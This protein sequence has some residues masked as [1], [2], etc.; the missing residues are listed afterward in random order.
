MTV[1]DLTR[2]LANQHLAYE[3]LP[4]RTTMTAGEEAVAIGI[5]A[6]EVAKT[7]VLFTDTG[8]VRVVLQASQR[9]DL[10]KV[11]KLLGDGTGTRLATEAELA[12]A[13]PMFELGAVPPV[14]GP[15]GD[16]TIVD[17]RLAT[18]DTVVIAAGSHS[19]SVRMRTQDLLALTRADVAD[20]SID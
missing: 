8:R 13:Y 20:I 5:P 7:L 4:H 14:G 1:E 2:V 16:R 18:R 9:L 10:R 17:D 6:T 11:R 15:A 3:L 19:K 12:D